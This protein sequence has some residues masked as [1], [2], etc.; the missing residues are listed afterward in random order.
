L[1][2]F[3]DWLG[4]RVTFLERIH[5]A[6]S[7]R[8]IRSGRHGNAARALW[9]RCSAAAIVQRG[10]FGNLARTPAAMAEPHPI[11]ATTSPRSLRS[12]AAMQRIPSSLSSS[13]MAQPRAR[14]PSSTFR[15]VCGSVM[16]CGVRAA[17]PSRTTRSTT[18]GGWNARIAC[19]SAVQ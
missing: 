10:L 19:P 4:Q 9:L 11:A 13:S 3:F 8:M 7:F 16:V 2:G 5:P 18:S 17:S 15:N 12:G 14:T 6:G 1:I